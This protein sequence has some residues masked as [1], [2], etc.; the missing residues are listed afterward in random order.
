MILK[1]NLDYTN[2]S[3]LLNNIISNL[4]YFEKLINEKTII[5]R[6]ANNAGFVNVVQMVFGMLILVGF[7]VFI[8]YLLFLVQ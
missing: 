7:S 3:M 4:N 1:Y 8:G 2:Y 5:N 6:N